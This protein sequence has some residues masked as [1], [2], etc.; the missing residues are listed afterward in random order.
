MNFK[1]FN[2]SPDFSLKAIPLAIL[3]AFSN[4]SFAEEDD[5]V[6][7][8]IRPESSVSFGIGSVSRDSQRFGMY[9]GLDKESVVGIGEFSFNRRNDETGTWI[10]AKGRNLGIPQAELKLEYSRQGAWGYFADIDQITRNTPYTI[11]SK[12]Q[13]SGSNS[14]SYPARSGQQAPA[15]GELP[16]L[17]TERLNS[18]L[19]FNY[20]FSPEFELKILFQNSEKKGGRPFGR[21]NTTSAVAF[22]QEFLVEP[23]DYTTRQLDVTLDYT[24]SRLQLSGGYYGS[25]F[26]NQNTQLNVAGGDTSLRSPAGGLPFSVIALPPDNFAHQLHLTGGYQI[27]DKT[28]S[29][30]KLAYSNAY[31]QDSFASLPVGGV[32]TSGR[33]DLGGS[34]KTTQANFGVT[35]RPIQNLFLLANLRYEDRQDNTPVV[36]YITGLSGSQSTDG[37]NEP[38]SLN[39]KSGKFEASYQLPLGYR[40]TGGVDL[41]QKDRSISGV[42]IV[43][44]RE[45]TDEVSYRAEIA[46]SLAEDLNGTISYVRSDRQGSDYQTLRQ[47]NW[48]TNAFSTTASPNQIQPIYIGDRKRD[49]VRLLTDWSPIEQ[50]NLQLAFEDARDAYGQGR[51][52]L[53]IG[54]HQGTARLYS[55][56]ATLSLNEKWRLTS[57]ISRSE[58]RMEQATGSSTATYWSTALTNRINALGIGV[59]G[60]LTGLIDIGADAIVSQDKSGFEMREA[61]IRNPLPEIKYNQ[62][63]LKLFGRYALDKDTSVRLDYIRDHR[64]TNDWTWNG[65]TTPYQY[66]DGTWFYQNPNE[67]VQF[68]GI[69]VRY[70]F[71]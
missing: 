4:C 9:N 44:Y 7:R 36:R 17:S 3:V 46:K 71:R 22:A 25:W 65:S 33:S 48:T 51:D 32:N 2:I 67:T 50:L 24:G 52:S 70:V 56:D 60:K 26:Q 18:R 19:G 59:R 13:G 53:N 39:I 41:E 58:N 14:L 57:W 37:Y 20:F 38:R 8:L 49:K 55:L 5:E 10:R 11:F 40:V 68:L 66:T 45:Q 47:W 15:T 54:P 62:S 21:G 12:L 63:T 28:R 29:T 27:T 23:V 34:L 35:S 31:Q 43:G 30:F 42:R 1:T 6:Q 69:S 16:A 64:Q 61:A